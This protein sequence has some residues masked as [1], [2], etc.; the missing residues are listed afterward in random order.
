MCDNNIYSTSRA[1]THDKSLTENMRFITVLTVALT[2]VTS[3]RA[4][5]N[6]PARKRS[7]FHKPKKY[8][9]ENTPKPPPPKLNTDHLPTV[10]E[11]LESLNLGHHTKLFYKQGITDTRYLLRM[12]PTDFN[13][14][15]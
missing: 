8:D 3:A 13:M 12:S 11:I 1:K 5:D 9:K 7:R 15:V 10:A 6:E 4:A 14:M 2:V